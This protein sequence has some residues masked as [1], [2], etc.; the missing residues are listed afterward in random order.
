MALVERGRYCRPVEAVGTGRVQTSQA[1]ISAS[2]KRELECQQSA[3]DEQ[4]AKS[5]AEGSLMSRL[6]P[7]YSL[8][9]EVIETL[10][11]LLRVKT[12]EA[13]RENKARST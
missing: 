13:R 3:P 11:A 2:F 5:N 8:P 4:S 9:F 12:Y 6:L 1:V 10:G 7:F